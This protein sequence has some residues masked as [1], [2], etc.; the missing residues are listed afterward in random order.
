MVG[1]EPAVVGVAAVAGA[2][3]D[4]ACVGEGFGHGGFET[5]GLFGCS[6][7]EVRGAEAGVGVRRSRVDIPQDVR[8]ELAEILD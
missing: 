4:D 6:R 5:H 8:R 7:G 2:A 3:R 1:V